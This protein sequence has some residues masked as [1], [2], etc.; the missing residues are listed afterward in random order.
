MALL[1]ELLGLDPGL[2]ITVLIVQAWWLILS[3]PI[4]ETTNS[5]KQ[6]G[7]SLCAATLG[8]GTKR[9]RDSQV[10]PQGLDMRFRGKQRAGG[11]H[12]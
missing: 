4:K 3:R 2:F 6:R 1:L 10:C 8:R 12:S 7:E 9:S 5:E 11:V